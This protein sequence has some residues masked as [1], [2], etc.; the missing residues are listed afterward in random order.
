MTRPPR[1]GHRVA[2][3]DQRPQLDADIADHY[4]SG[5]PEAAR[6]TRPGGMVFAAAISRLAHD[7][8]L[9]RDIGAAGH[10]L[11]QDELSL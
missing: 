3:P 1:V 7:T 4:G 10:R 6:V 11:W 9:A 8:H 2:V 5:R